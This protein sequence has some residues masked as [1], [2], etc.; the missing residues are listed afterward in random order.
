VEVALYSTGKVLALYSLF[1]VIHWRRSLGQRIDWF[2]VSAGLVAWGAVL[3][4]VDAVPST[5]SRHLPPALGTMLASGLA[6]GLLL[7]VEPQQIRKAVVWMLASGF[8]VVAV[9]LLDHAG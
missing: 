7:T 6:V 1:R 2:Q 8:A 4:I 3:M 5:L 9:N